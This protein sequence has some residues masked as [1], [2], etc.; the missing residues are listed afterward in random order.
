[1]SDRS[2]WHAFAAL[3]VGGAVLFPAGL[4]AQR[5]VEMDKEQKIKDWGYSIRT[6]KSWNAMP[7][8][9]HERFVVGYWKFDTK[10]LEMRGDYEASWNGQANAV[11]IVRIPTK[12]AST[13][14]PEEQK[15]LEEE[16]R[17]TEEAIKKYGFKG[18]LEKLLR[19][20]SM[21]DWIEGHYEDAEK[22]WVK[23]PLKGGK[24]PGEVVE[25]GK[26]QEMVV[27]AMFVKDGVEWG[28]VYTSHEETYRKVWADP[29]M[30]S[31]QSFIV[32]GNANPDLAAMQ[33]KD[34][35]KLEGDEKR[36]AIKA[37]IEGQPGWYSLDSKYYV[38]L[39]NSKEKGF[40]EDMKRDLELVRE[41]IYTRY[42]PPRNKAETLSPVRVYS[43]Q[44]DYHQAG[45]P[46]G[47]A[48]FFNPQSGEL[49][50]F[51]KFEDQSKTSS[52]ADCRSVMFHEGF[53]QYVH[54]AI[55][56][57]SPHS[58]FNEGHGDF[59]AGINVAGGQISF[60]R[61]DWRV[62]F[63]RRHLRDGKDL[64]PLR[65]LVR[66]PQN[67]YYSNAGLKY[68]QGWALIYYLREVTKN[69]RLETVLD[70]YFAH[71]ADNVAAFKQKKKESGDTSPFG[72]ESIPGLPGVRI[73]NFEDTEKVEKILSE[74]VDK[75]FVGLD[76]E[77]LDKDFREWCKKL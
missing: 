68:S 25:F 57:V 66:M 2:C 45:G 55:G 21:I 5:K 31:I 36:A 60:R 76:L 4:S 58:W 20:K 13:G 41:K 75:A 30:K 40:L 53:H 61:F 17:K 14:T 67:E 8:P 7:A 39:S 62:D 38:F 43:D 48:G 12:V 37:Q 77:A 64:I 23:K 44:N 16:N 27:A 9:Q 65:T 52:L 49:V 34:I 74:A 42:F 71:V 63:L 51:V 50:L 3:V 56:D 19:P 6:L 15:K 33:R 46:Y 54:F 47:S 73:Y 70:T 11:M 26:G 69:K 59:F 1:M 35:T 22:R 24:M 72:G 10:D 32:T 29:Y 18:N 28:V